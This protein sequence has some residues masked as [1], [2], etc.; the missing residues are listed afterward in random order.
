[1]LLSLFLD[2]NAQVKK[3][4]QDVKVIQ[5]NAE[6][7]HSSFFSYSQKDQALKY[8]Y[9]PSPNYNLLSG[10]WYFKWSY[11]PSL[12]PIDF[13]RED[14]DI[15]SWNQIPVPSDW[16]MPPGEQPGTLC[17]AWKTSRRQIAQ[18]PRHL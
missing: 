9:L 6:K 10:N 8:T 13:Y 4:W 15:S 16:Q 12:R 1:M 14:Y 17:P 2:L 7:P 11:N 3:E 5:V 18:G